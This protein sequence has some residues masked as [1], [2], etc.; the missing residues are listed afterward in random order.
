MPQVEVAQRV[1]KTLD[2]KVPDTKPLTPQVETAQQL[3]TAGWHHLNNS[4]TFTETHLSLEYD[5]LMPQ[6]GMAQQLATAGSAAC[7]K[8]QILKAQF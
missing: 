1:L 7:R 5:D 6:V 3:A 4:K 8:P 2:S